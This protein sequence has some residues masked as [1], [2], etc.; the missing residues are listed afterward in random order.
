MNQ[1]LL[2]QHEV[3]LGRNCEIP[4]HFI[5]KF[6]QINGFQ[7]GTVRD[8][9][10]EFSSSSLFKNS[11]E[12]KTDTSTSETVSLT[13]NHFSN[14]YGLREKLRI[15]HLFLMNLF[16]YNANK[17]SHPPNTPGRFFWAVLSIIALYGSIKA[18]E[19]FLWYAEIFLFGTDTIIVY[20]RQCLNIER[21]E[22]HFTKYS[23][24]QCDKISAQIK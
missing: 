10:T 9:H 5:F 16:R 18:P 8:V 7:V 12:K 2:L 3:Q 19:K 20:R 1:I 6:V 15:R 14:Q 23:H 24:I 4:I 21:E 17:L 11:I 22:K 13:A